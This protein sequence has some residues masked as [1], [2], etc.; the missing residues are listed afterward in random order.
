MEE[1]QEDK[2]WKFRQ[3]LTARDCTEGMSERKT[4]SEMK[5]QWLLASINRFYPMIRLFVPP[6]SSN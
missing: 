3:L 4:G 2:I 6:T 5:I 1:E